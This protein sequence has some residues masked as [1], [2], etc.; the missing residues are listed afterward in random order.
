MTGQNS[1][2]S[3]VCADNSGQ[4]YGGRLVFVDLWDTLSVDGEGE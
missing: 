3:G 2:D 1:V 4:P